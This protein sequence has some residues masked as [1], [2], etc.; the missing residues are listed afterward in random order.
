MSRHRLFDADPVEDVAIDDAPTGPVTLPPPGHVTLV[1]RK[2]SE[3][4]GPPEPAPSRPSWMDDRARAW[5]DAPGEFARTRPTPTTPPVTP[6]APVAPPRLLPA[7]PD[8]GWGPWPPD[9]E[10]ARPRSGPLPVLAPRAPARRGTSALL[11]A[12]IVLLVGML[13]V[14]GVALVRP[15]LL[16]L[17]G[18]SPFAT[19]GESAPGA[20]TA[21]V[22]PGS[23]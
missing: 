14:L 17:A 22:V 10:L 5:A 8:D 1:P 21:Q 18:R 13:A 12:T 19:A 16:G 15:D 4:V 3:L 23:P 11:V 9:P 20:S 2:P 6:S 7:R